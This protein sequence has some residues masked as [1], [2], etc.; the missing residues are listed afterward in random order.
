M[1][2]FAG[3]QIGIVVLIG[4]FY[5]VIV[6]FVTSMIANAPHDARNPPPP[7]EA[8]VGI[9]VVIMMFI[10][11]V[12]LIFCIPKVVA[13]YGLRRGKSYAKLWTIIACVL[14]V[15]S[16]PLG[17]AV[18]VYGLWFVFGDAGKAFFDGPDFNPSPVSAP[19]PNN[20]A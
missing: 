13:A 7:P 12:T 15:M 18:G 5:A 19:P 8:I 10:I 14:A 6:G 20:W 11:V 2:I 17:T 9:F 1:W 3:L 4:I 16:F